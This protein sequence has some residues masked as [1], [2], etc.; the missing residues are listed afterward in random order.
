MRESVGDDI[1]RPRFIFNSIIEAEKLGQIRL[2][3]R[4]LDDLRH[5]VL[6]AFVIRENGERSSQ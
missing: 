1:G 2:L 4:G 3:F 5:E 6:Q